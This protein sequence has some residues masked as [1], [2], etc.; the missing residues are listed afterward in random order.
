MDEIKDRLKKLRK[1]LGMTQDEFS[2]KIGLARNSIA[3]YEIGRRE[4]TNAIIVS[5]CREFGVN[6]IWLRT[7]EGGDE[8]MFTK[9]P[10]DDRF[11]INLGKLSMTE[12]EM[13]KN[14]LNAIAEASPEKLKHLEEFMKVCLGIK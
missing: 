11:S 4:P 8:N 9:I 12:N 7:G 10:E 2:K 13:A 3:N 14:M 6:E 5:L 1:N